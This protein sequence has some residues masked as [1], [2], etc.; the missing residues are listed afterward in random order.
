LKKIEKREDETN[1]DFEYNQRKQELFINDLK[2]F[3]IKALILDDY[4]EITE[5]LKCVEENLKKNTVFISG[6]AAEFNCWNKGES[7]Y[8]IHS[9]SKELIKQNFNIVSGFGLGVGS[10]VIS[11]ALEEIYLNQGKINEER[12]TLRPFPQ[13]VLGNQ[14]RDLLWARYREDMI[15]RSGVSIYVFGNKIEDGN[16]VNANGVA[17]EFEIAHKLGNLVVPIGATGSISKELWEK[18]KKDFTSYY[19]MFTNPDLE[20]T[21]DNLNNEKLSNRELVDEIIK[22]VQMLVN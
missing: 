2:R 13:N 1:A 10:L 16:L 5:I 9:L 20:E 12:L 7:E 17:S 15:S 14:D 21:F 6:S 4:S 8:F 3:N 11:G 22:F 19:P 18:V